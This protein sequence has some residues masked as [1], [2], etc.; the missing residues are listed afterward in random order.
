MAASTQASTSAAS[1]STAEASTPTASTSKL[2]SIGSSAASSK[3]DDVKG[4]AVEEERQ[5]YDDSDIDRIL[6]QEATGVQRDEEV[7][8]PSPR[9]AVQSA[10]TDL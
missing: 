2:A 4:K 1:T 10:L 8:L 3:G 9:S 5:P 7:R 6:A